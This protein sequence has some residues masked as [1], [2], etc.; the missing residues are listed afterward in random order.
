VH[1]LVAASGQ[2]GESS[3]RHTGESNSDTHATVTM[4]DLLVDHPKILSYPS[5]PFLPLPPVPCP[6]T[7]H[8]QEPATPRDPRSPPV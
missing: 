1:V 5:D 4:I 7:G 8:S 2:Q 3:G 6:P